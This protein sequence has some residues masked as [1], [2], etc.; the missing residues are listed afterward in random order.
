MTD[1]IS[2]LTLRIIQDVRAE[3]AA[4][5]HAVDARD[6]RM[7]AELAA[8]RTETSAKLDLLAEATVNLQEANRKQTG[9][10]EILAMAFSRQGERLERIETRLDR[11][12]QKLALDQTQH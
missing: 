1:D 9:R 6:E 8:F 4:W 11:V 3:N 7:R 12:E 10:I 2:D 5:R